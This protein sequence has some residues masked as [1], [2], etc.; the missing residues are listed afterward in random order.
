[1]CLGPANL[2]PSK[3]LYFAGLVVLSFHSLAQL[4]GVQIKPDYKF[5]QI[6]KI[7]RWILY[8]LA[9]NATV[10]LVKGFSPIAILRNQI[11][12]LIFVC[13]FPIYIWCGSKI[14]TEHI[15]DLAVIVGNFS[16]FA[17]WYLWSQGHGL[18]TFSTER[19][20]LSSEWTAF[21]GL[22]ICLNSKTASKARKVFYFASTLIVCLFML[23]SLTRTNILLI[24]WII[25]V[26][27]ITGSNRIS[28]AMRLGISTVLGI[29]FL[30]LFIPGLFSNAA[31]VG[32][33]LNSWQKY[34]IGGLGTSGIGA[35]QSVLM[36][37]QQTAI[38]NDIFM[39]N[40]FFGCGQLPSGQIFDTI[41]GSIAK[42]GIVG[43]VIF[44]SI[45]LRIFRLFIRRGAWKSSFYLPFGSALIPA[46]LIYNWPDGRGIWLA[47]GLALTIYISKEI[48]FHK[49]GSF[50]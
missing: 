36:R 15:M 42:F 27:L 10:S 20:A 2:T 24:L 32:R 25:C 33:I 6:K 14:R 46:S 16:A 28:N 9:L 8:L 48:D 1:M 31:F 3:F 38:A 43:L 12:I 23:L 5:I 11:A 26:S 37:H 34:K 7:A 18:N 41:L 39:N 47:L 44:L 49:A 45:Y 40:L 30:K 50:T 35:D 21:L 17:F 22:A 19:I 29:I 4:K 13:G